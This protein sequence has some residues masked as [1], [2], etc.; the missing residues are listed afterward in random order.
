MYFSNLVEL[1]NM[2]GHGPFVWSAYAISFIVL[3]AII[4]IPAKHYRQQLKHIR[5]Q[6]SDNC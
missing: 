2:A 4:V 6:Q 3:A 1:W 5:Q